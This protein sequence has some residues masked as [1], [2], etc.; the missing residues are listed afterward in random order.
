MSENKKAKIETPIIDP[1]K[2]VDELAQ[3]ASIA[4]DKMLELSQEQIDTIESYGTCRS[5]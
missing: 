4:L 5:F 1:I 2:M 3:K